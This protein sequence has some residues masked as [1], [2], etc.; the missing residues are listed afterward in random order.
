M[1]QI[2]QEIVEKIEETKK[3]QKQ[4]EDAR[5]Y[6]EEYKIKQQK[7]EEDKLRKRAKLLHEV[8]RNQDENEIIILSDSYSNLP[9]DVQVSLELQ[10][11]MKVK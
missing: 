3:L 5:K 8:K 9:E 11:H 1:N 10:Y 4:I 7:A 6:E 2:Q